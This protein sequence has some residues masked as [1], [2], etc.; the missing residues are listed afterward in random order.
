MRKILLLIA[1][2]LPLPIKLFVYKFI[3]WSI[4]KNVKIGFSYINCEHCILK[5]NV[6]IGNFNIIRRLTLFQIGGGPCI[7]NFNQ[8]FFSGNKDESPSWSGKIIL[9]EKVNIMSHHFIDAGGSVNVGKNTTIAGRDSHIW[10]HGISYINGSTKKEKLRY[11]VNVG[12]NVYVGARVSILG[13]SVPDQAMVGAGSVV[14][15]SFPPEEYPILIAGNPAIVK[16]RYELLN[17]LDK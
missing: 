3:G 12:R 17:N 5:D 11:E 9:E 8:F 10:N 16:K 13:C 2:I 15:K 7:K 1:V 6:T 4:G 14:N